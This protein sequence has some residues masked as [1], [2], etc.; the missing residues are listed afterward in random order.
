MI[1]DIKKYS[2]CIYALFITSS[3]VRYSYHLIFVQSLKISI[4]EAATILRLLRML[5]L[6]FTDGL[7]PDVQQ[8]ILLEVSH[9]AFTL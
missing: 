5:S 3:S 1:Y 4:N 2:K 6:S 9:T 7:C 8:L